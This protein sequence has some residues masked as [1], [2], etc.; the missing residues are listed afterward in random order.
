MSD[1]KCQTLAEGNG[2][3]IVKHRNI[4]RGVQKIWNFDLALSIGIKGLSTR[5]N[6]IRSGLF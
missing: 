6:L 1:W 5:S 3:I 2:S 4:V